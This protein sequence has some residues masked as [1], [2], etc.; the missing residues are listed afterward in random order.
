MVFS[1]SISSVGAGTVHNRCKPEHFN[2]SP[3][4][5]KLMSPENDFYQ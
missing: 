1:A 2:N 4:E 3:E 5:I